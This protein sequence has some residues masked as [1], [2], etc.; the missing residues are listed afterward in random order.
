MALPR[1]IEQIPFLL[2]EVIKTYGEPSHVRAFHFF[3]PH[4]G[5]SFY[6]FAIM[7]ADQGFSL[8]QR[9]LRDYKPLINNQMVFD[10]VSFDPL[11]YLIDPAVMVPWAGFKQFEF[12]CS[13][14][15][16]LSRYV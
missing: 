5:G 14:E 9:G 2:E 1:I 12:Y 6:V 10:Q 13:K 11:P 16:R 7:Y 15:L 3:D 8:T 4:G